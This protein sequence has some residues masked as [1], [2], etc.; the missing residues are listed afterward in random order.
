MDK[1]C[2]K[3]A[4]C[5]IALTESVTS[6]KND[7]KWILRICTGTVT[8]ISLLIALFAVYQKSRIAEASNGKNR[9][10]QPRCVNK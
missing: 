6:I 1:F 3:H 2:N 7:I 9:L 4:E 8:M 10:E 5:M